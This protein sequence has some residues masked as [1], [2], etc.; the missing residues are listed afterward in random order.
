MSTYRLKRGVAERVVVTLMAVPSASI[1]TAEEVAEKTGDTLAD[2]QL[3]LDALVSMGFAEK[4]AAP[5]SAAARAFEGAVRKLTPPCG[6][7]IRSGS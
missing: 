2:V 7:R 6:T 5:P 1:L 4:D 3:M